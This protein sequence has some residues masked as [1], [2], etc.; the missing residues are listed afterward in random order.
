LFIVAKIQS[1]PKLRKICSAEI[2][3]NYKKLKSPHDPSKLAPQMCKLVNPSIHYVNSNPNHHNRSTIST[4]D[5]L[6]LMAKKEDYV[7]AN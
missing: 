3:N 4:S 1:K 2:G 5:K 6:F 7:N